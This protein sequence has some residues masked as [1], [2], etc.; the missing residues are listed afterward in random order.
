[1]TFAK[2]LPYYA[3]KICRHN[4]DGTITVDY[5]TITGKP[6]VRSCAKYPYSYSRY[7]IYKTKKW[8]RKDEMLYSDR[9][10]MWFPDTYYEYK[11]K[12]LGN[13]DDLKRYHPDNIEKF[14]SALFGYPIHITGME[15]ECNFSNGYPY[16]IIYYT[17]I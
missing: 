5:L 12:F 6:Q 8:T 15:E 16:W 4:P 13:A 10:S 1:M 7:C 3:P 11:E 17:K 9:L 2:G 14:I